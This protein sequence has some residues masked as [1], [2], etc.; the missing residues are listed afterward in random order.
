MDGTTSDRTAPRVVA[1]EGGGQ[2]ARHV[3]IIMDGNGRWAARRGL[4]RYA[5]H[6]RGVDSLREVVEACPD[7]GVQT[8]TLFAFSTENWR[9]PRAE[10][11]GLMRLFRHY[12]RREAAELVTKGVRVRFIGERAS[13]PKDIQALMASLEAQTADCD[14]FAVIIAINYGGRADI[15]AAARQVARDV[16]A[17]VLAPEDVSE[18]S[19]AARLATAD[20]PDPDLVIRTSG[21]Q[22]ISNFLL[23]QSAYAEFVFA[24]EL[25]P[26]FD[27]AAFERA[28]GVFQGRQRRFGAV[29]G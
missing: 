21:E 11:E 9:R 6:Q 16:A 4:S 23:W 22:R 29:V 26:D 28:L 10:I 2:P 19:V 25:W 1:V 27:R 20:L 7:L 8:L 24:P 13:L 14:Q 18:A 3:A 17:G 5:G 12:L 15:A